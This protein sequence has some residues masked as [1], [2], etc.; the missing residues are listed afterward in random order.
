[1][2]CDPVAERT[3]GEKSQVIMNSLQ[4]LSSTYRRLVHADL[5]SQL[6]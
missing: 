5:I 4:S 3:L 6:S 1:M 2:L